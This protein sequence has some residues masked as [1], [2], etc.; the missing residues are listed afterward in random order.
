[1]LILKKHFY[2][3]KMKLK[4]LKIW[5][6]ENTLLWNLFDKVLQPRFLYRFLFHDFDYKKALHRKQL[7]IQCEDIIGFLFI[8][9]LKKTSRGQIHFCICIPYTM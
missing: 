2:F 5:E 3:Y 7:C 6:M 1:M 8:V 9:M 4:M